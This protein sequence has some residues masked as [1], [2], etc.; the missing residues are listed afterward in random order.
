MYGGDSVFVS[1]KPKSGSSMNKL[2][3]TTLHD[4]FVG[5]LNFYPTKISFL[6][7]RGHTYDY[8]KV[9]I[10]FGTDLLSQRAF[11]HQVM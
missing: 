6:F 2:F 9:V 1:P 3:N 7:F 4:Y 11:L 5:Q 10:V 8:I